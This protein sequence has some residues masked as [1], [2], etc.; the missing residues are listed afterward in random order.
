MNKLADTMGFSIVECLEP[1]VLLEFVCLF[2]R[3]QIKNICFDMYNGTESRM[4]EFDSDTFVVRTDFQFHGKD[5]NMMLKHLK[6]LEFNQ[7]QKVTI[8]YGDHYTS[9][10][11]DA[12]NREMFVG[13]A[14]FIP[15]QQIKDFH[16]AHRLD[17]TTLQI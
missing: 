9:C 4:Q 6:K 17:K 15:L 3:D 7:I 13:S 1:K 14:D 10:Y 12:L 5:I 2:K 16:K 11:L 8:E